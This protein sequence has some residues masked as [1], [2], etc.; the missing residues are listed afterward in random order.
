MLSGELV[1]LRERREDDEV[2]LY[3]LAV[4]LEIWEWCRLEV[5]MPLICVEFC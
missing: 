5:L 4:D 2:L 1:R 3:E